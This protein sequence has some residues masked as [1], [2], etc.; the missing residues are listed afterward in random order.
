MLKAEQIALSI[1]KKNIALNVFE[2]NL[3]AI[4]AYK[5]Q[6]FIVMKRN[7]LSRYSRKKRETDAIL[8]KMK[9]IS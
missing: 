4:S 9:I 2:S 6:G 8:K 1:G 7:E 3:N 5:K